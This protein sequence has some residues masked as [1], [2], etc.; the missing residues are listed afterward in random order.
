MDLKWVMTRLMPAGNDVACH[1][2]SIGRRRSD[3]RLYRW[4]EA[5]THASL[6]VGL[7]PN[8]EEVAD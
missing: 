5:D 6:C 4:L 8:R 3:H 7:G 2:Q 1:A